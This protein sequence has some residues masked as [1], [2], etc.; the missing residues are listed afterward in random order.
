[1]KENYRSISLINVDAKSSTEY[2]KTESSNILKELYTMSK[3]DLS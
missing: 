1:M 2:W 3:W